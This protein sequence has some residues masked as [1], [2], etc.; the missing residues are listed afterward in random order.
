VLRYQNQSVIRTRPRSTRIKICARDYQSTAPD[1]PTACH[2]L[3]IPLHPHRPRQELLFARKIEPVCCTRLRPLPNG[4]ASARIR[5]SHVYSNEKFGTEIGNA[6]IVQ[7]AN[8]PV[9]SRFKGGLAPNVQNHYSAHIAQTNPPC[10]LS[11]FRSAVA[12][13]AP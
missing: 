7:P 13:N 10:Q 8:F 4:P 3:R 6:I 1:R 5:S 2:R 9:L 11:S 12:G